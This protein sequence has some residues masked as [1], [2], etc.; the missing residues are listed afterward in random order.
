MIADAISGIKWQWKRQ[1]YLDKPILQTLIGCDRLY[2]R[3]IILRSLS[4]PG[5]PNNPFQMNGDTTISYVKV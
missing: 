4:S 5:T 3:S 2:M 1:S